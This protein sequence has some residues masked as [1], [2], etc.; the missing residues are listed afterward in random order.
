MTENIGTLCVHL[1]NATHAIDSRISECTNKLT[2]RSLDQLIDVLNYVKW[3]ESNN[4]SQIKASFHSAVNDIAHKYNIERNTIADLCV[5][6]LG[7]SST[8]QFTNLLEAWLL[9][10]SSTI[11]GIIKKHANYHQHIVIDEFFSI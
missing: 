11:V 4:L 3:T 10:G 8:G 5:R 2:Q 1:M 6:R 9:N 7:L